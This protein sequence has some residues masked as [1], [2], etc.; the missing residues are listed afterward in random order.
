[1]NKG[2][3]RNKEIVPQWIRNFIT[4][5]QRQLLEE[6]HRRRLGGSEEQISHNL[7]LLCP[8]NQ[9]EVEAI[10]AGAYKLREEAIT[11]SSKEAGRLRKVGKFVPD[12]GISDD[13]L[14][15]ELYLRKLLLVPLNRQEMHEAVAKY[16]GWGKWSEDPWQSFPRFCEWI[17]NISDNEQAVWAVNDTF[18]GRVYL[19][20]G[21]LEGLNQLDY[22]Q[23]TEEDLL[24]YIGVGAENFLWVKSYTNW[25]D[26][27]SY[28][29]KEPLPTRLV[30]E[31]VIKGYLPYPLGGYRYFVSSIYLWHFALKATVERAKDHPELEAFLSYH[32]ATDARMSGLCRELAPKGYQFPNQNEAWIKLEQS[33]KKRLEAIARKYDDVYPLKSVQHDVLSESY[34]TAQESLLQGVNYYKSK[35]HAAVVAGLEGQLGNRLVSVVEHDFADA[36]GK[37]H[38]KHEVTESQIEATRVRDE[39]DNTPFLDTIPSQEPMPEEPIDLKSLGFDIDKL[40]LKE[41]SL[42]HELQDL[43][44]KGYERHSKQ[45]LSPRQYWG[46]DYERKMKM[47]KR[48]EAKRKKL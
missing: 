21:I 48:L 3:G 20:Y 44:D 33:M 43:V 17:H 23:M 35:A 24:T 40:T 30:N 42:L 15:S 1:M 45:G 29:P 18:G 6:E 28:Y 31:Q 32:T 10:R 37:A 13:S 5:R 9:D 41:V 22:S 27:D 7:H 11:A 34:V 8:F 47:W 25:D 39:G 19:T 2:Q 16:Y 36:A 46:K 12:S 4:Q 38:R 14:I 26:F